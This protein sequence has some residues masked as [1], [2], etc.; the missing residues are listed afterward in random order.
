MLKES[1]VIIVN[2]FHSYETV[3]FRSDFRC[4]K[5]F[6]VQWSSE[7]KSILMCFCQFCPLCELNSVG[8][9]FCCEICFLGYF[10]VNSSKSVQILMLSIHML[11]YSIG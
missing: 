5:M 8:I 11:S 10:T 2:N 4:D 3:T 7:E 6:M 1:H 9:H